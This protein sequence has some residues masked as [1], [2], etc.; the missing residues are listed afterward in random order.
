M[1]KAA[2]PGFDDPGGDGGGGGGGE[3]Y[4]PATPG[5]GWSIDASAD[6]ITFNLA[7]A[8]G[9]NNITVSEFAAGALTGT[10]RFSLGSWSDVYGYPSE[11]EFFADRLWFANTPTN[12][13]MFWATNAG[14]YT[15]FGRNTPVID[16]DSVSFQINSRQVNAVMDL[17]PLS[18]LLVLTKGGEFIVGGGA[19]N[20]I[21]PSSISADPQSYCGSD[22]TQAR[23]ANDTAIFIQEQGS[24]VMDLGYRFEADGFRPKD[25]SVWAEHLVQGYRI[26][27][28][29]W[30]PAPWSMLPMVRNDGVLIG[31]TYMPEQEV[32]GWHR[33]D[34]GKTPAGYGL[35]AFEDIACLPGADQTE[36]FAI[37]RRVVDGQVV[38]YIEQ[39]A[40]LEVT[41]NRDWFY[42]D[43]GLTY[44]GRNK[45]ATT[46]TL[47]GG[48]TW[49]EDE[50][51]TLTASAPLFVGAGDVGDGFL[52]EVTAVV[53]D[54]AG[55]PMEV[56][57]S[58]RV[59][60]DEFISTTV[61]SVT[62]I[63]EV[64]APLR[65]APITGWTFQRDEITGLDHL[66]GRRV[67][68]LADAAVATPRIV[69]G[70]AITL[71]SPAGVVHVGLPYRAH[72]ET[73]EVNEQG[74]SPI[75]GSQKLMTEVGVQVLASREV[76]ACSGVLREEYLDELKVREF[77]EYAEPNR[78]LTG[79]GRIPLS[80]EWGVNNGRVHIVSDDPLPCRILALTPKL[81]SGEVP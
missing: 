81:M 15:N 50:A 30:M 66:E 74:G 27:R 6:T 24:R 69:A 10:T 33:H 2:E 54:D 70:G 12:P 52:L 44:D 78:P 9:T 11:V 20:V 67:A 80:S 17:I 77:E 14:D 56:T 53:S 47:S 59:S 61:V 21:T 38:R 28:L 42:V 29:E 4:P 41:D 45:G 57:Y 23:V 35:D 71:D 49:N 72:I 58:V 63:G 34:T 26:Q 79:Y 22:G 55:Y 39:L 37:V 32:I 76:R 18:S 13:Q 64:P 62:S 60:I 5:Q 3:Y 65:G 16:S 68:I 46:V 75:R 31:C 8:A 7:P 1:L 73:L 25:L 19:D 36:L 43:S 48:S 51:L 40:P